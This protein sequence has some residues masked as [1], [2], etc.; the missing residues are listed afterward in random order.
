M[1]LNI[2]WTRIL[3]GW[4][5]Y[6]RINS[7]TLLLSRTVRNLIYQHPKALNSPP[8]DQ[9]RLR[10]IPC[11]GIEWMLLRARICLKILKSRLGA[12]RGQIWLGVQI[13]FLIQKSRKNNPCQIIE[14]F[15]GAKIFKGED[16]EKY[17]PWS[18]NQKIWVK[19]SRIWEKTHSSGWHSSTS[20][21]SVTA[22]S[23]VPNTKS[24][25]PLQM[26]VW[27]N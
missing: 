8:R 25:D 15:T 1:L 22:I 12:L 17:K 9:V 11:P 6:L 19:W 16:R 13:I 26:E 2:W 27:P 7:T 4:R 24:Q 21:K 20:N 5:I 10:N 3:V 18:Q 14:N 23:N